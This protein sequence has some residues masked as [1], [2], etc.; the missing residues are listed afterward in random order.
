[1]P[2]PI[3]GE[4]RKVVARRRVNRDRTDASPTRPILYAAVAF[5]AVAIGGHFLLPGAD[6]LW[7]VLVALGVLAVPQ[8]LLIGRSER[9][10]KP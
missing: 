7:V 3:P 9:R 6:V 1:V 10:N 8:A 4:Q 2:G 5:L